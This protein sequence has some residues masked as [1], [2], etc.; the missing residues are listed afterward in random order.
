[1][2]HAPKRVSNAG[3]APQWSTD[4]VSGDFS[5]STSVNGGRHPSGV[6]GRQR[7]GPRRTYEADGEP[8]KDE[9]SRPPVGRVETRWCVVGGGQRV[10]A[11]EWRFFPAGTGGG[12]GE[13]GSD[14]G[15]TGPAAARP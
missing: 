12:G 11:P 13:E 8:G 9:W 3:V 4:K 15:S 5:R 14:A 2:S 6:E 10:G 7:T 1:M